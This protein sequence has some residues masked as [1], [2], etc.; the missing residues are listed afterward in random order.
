MPSTTY[1]LF[2]QAIVGRK[3]VLCTYDSYSRELCPIILGRTYSGQEAALTWQFAGESKTRLPA[4]GEWRCLHLAKVSNVQLRDGPW[5][6]GRSH[7]RPQH[8]VDI[9]DLDVNPT[10]PYAPK[11][12]T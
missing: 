10:S 6:S 11:R 8:C 12:R 5:Y 4:L 7:T 1:D 2:G 3:Q 9:V